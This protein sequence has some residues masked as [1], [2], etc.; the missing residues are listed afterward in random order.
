MG[1]FDESGAR[2]DLEEFLDS[3]GRAARAPD[4]DQAAR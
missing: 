1:R 3:R 4:D 2:R